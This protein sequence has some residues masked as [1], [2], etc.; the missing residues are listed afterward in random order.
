MR[1]QPRTTR[2]EDEEG[3][4]EVEVDVSLAA[5]DDN[6][7]SAR[8]FRI[9]W[10]GAKSGAREAAA[11]ISRSVVASVAAP[12]VTAAAAAADVEAKER[13]RWICRRRIGDPGAKVVAGANAAAVAR[14]CG[15]PAAPHVVSFI[16]PRATRMACW[17]R[18]MRSR[19]RVAEDLWR[20]TREEGGRWM[21]S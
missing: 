11:G 4:E 1:T 13:A 18:S 3:E 21:R 8:I 10:R 14:G 7:A 15:G 17:P 9:V 6:A 20:G 16:V 2:G 12:S 19:R 5:D